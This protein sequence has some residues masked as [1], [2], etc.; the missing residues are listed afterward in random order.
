MIFTKD[1]FGDH[2][3]WGVSTAAYQ[4]EGG[5]LSDGKGP[6]IWDEFVKMKGK[7]QDGTHAD[8]SCDHYHR[9]EEDIKIISRLNI[10]NYRLSLAWSR[11]LPDGIGQVNPKGLDFYDRLID[12]C[13]EHNVNPWVTLYHWDL[14]Q[15]LQALGGWTNREVL[16]WFQEFSELCTRKFGDRVKNWMVLNE[17]MVFTGAGYFLGYH[18]PGLKGL[19]NFIPAMH[20]ATLC[21]SLG[22]RVIRDEVPNAKI[23]TTFSC[24]HVDPR[25][26]DKKDVDAARRFDALLNRLFIE[27]TLGLGYPVNDLPIAGRVDKYMKPEDESKMAFDF[28]FIGIQNYTREIVK[29]TWFVP[30][31]QGQIVEA[32]T[33]EV[34]TTTMGWEVYPKSIY[35]MLKKYSQYDGVKEIVVTENGA[36]FPD[37]LKENRIEDAERVKF[38]QS[39][40][41]EMLKAKKEGVNVTG[42]FLWT[43]MDN[44]EWAEGYSQ[45]FGIVH[46]DFESLKRTIKDSG[47]W[48]SRFLKSSK[49]RQALESS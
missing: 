34:E 20:H 23:G 12:S 33:R 17:P 10:P 46:V 44:F 2:F 16:N 8:Q 39:Y 3:D 48:Y 11:I 49:V 36:A 29:H 40:I 47:F 24:S 25:S 5:H 14:P 19:G 37:V 43:L 30:Y 22:A 38:L 31:L 1:D 27:P 4:I 7:I 32:Q 28:D 15:K 45:R 6:S 13:L 26:E 18:A 9:F 41:C 42:Y 21:Q 35:H